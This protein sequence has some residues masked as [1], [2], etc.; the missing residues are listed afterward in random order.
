MPEKL[1]LAGCV[2]LQDQ[3]ILVIHR[4]KKDWWELPG[5]KI[6]K[7]EDAHDAAIRELKEE[8]LCDVRIVKKLGEMDFMEND[9]VMGYEW[10]L[11]EILKG[12][13]AVGEPGKYD[14]IGFKS[15]LELRSQ[16][17][18][19]NMLNLLDAIERGEIQI[20]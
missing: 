5:G 15:I 9:F 4:V 18:S 3:K 16:N 6:E 19:P 8:I 12:D 14:N 10:F 2:I 17:I 1:Q 20:S 11:A 13:P 7:G